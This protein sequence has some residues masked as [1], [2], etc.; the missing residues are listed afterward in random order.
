MSPSHDGGRPLF[1]GD[2]DLEFLHAACGGG[3]DRAP[4]VIVDDLQWMERASSLVLGFVTRRLHRTRVGFL[5]AFRSGDESFFERSGLRGHD[6]GPLV[7]AASTAML[8]D[9]LPALALGCAAVHT[10]RLEEAIAPCQSS[11]PGKS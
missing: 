10:G 4:L 9:R 3:L 5:A 11:T 6:L 8:V 2:E 1:G 7:D